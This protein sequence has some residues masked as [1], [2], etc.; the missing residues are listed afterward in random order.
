MV[1]L[2]VH[3]PTTTWSK[4]RRAEERK[5][6]GKRKEQQRRKEEGEK[7]SKL[8][9]KGLLEL[10]NSSSTCTDTYTNTRS[11]KYIIAIESQSPVVFVLP[12]F[13]SVSR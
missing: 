8:A 10:Y 6:Y 9:L 5:V 2:F 11:I 1:Q 12:V 3:R 13:I 4:E 7:C